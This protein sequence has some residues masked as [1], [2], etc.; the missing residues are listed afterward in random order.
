M[1]GKGYLRTESTPQKPAAIGGNPQKFVYGPEILFPWIDDPEKHR[2]LMKI[3]DFFRQAYKGDNVQWCL[4]VCK[5]GGYRAT[6]LLLKSAG[7]IVEAPNL[8]AGTNVTISVDG[9]NITI[10]AG[11]GGD[12][13][14]ASAFTADNR[15]VTT[16]RPTTDNKNVQQTPVTLDGSGEMIGLASLTMAERSSAAPI[17]AAQGQFWIKDDAPS[18]PK[19]TDDAGTDHNIALEDGPGVM[20]ST[21]VTITRAQLNALGAVTAGNV[22]VGFTWPAGA[23]YAGMRGR[24]G[25]TAFTSSGGTVTNL[26]AAPVVSGRTTAFDLYLSSLYSA[27][28]RSHRSPAAGGL[29]S[30]D[31]PY[32]DGFTMDVRL[33]VSGTSVTMAN[34]TDGDD[35]I[36]LEIF[37]TEASS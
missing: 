32:E 11:G 16:D 15:I 24:N 5:L 19:F 6:A 36:I 17:T 25:G 29:P 9:S 35:G 31:F 18:V 10:A 33:D 28:T 3:L 30:A 23:R 27:D 4:N 1:Q 14:A 7:S 2:S 12:V 37:Y 8:V 13:S 21:T 26:R 20:K 34:L 22:T